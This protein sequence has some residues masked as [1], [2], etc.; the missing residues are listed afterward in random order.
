VLEC[1]YY[2]EPLDNHKTHITKA[3]NTFFFSL[4]KTHSQ[5]NYYFFALL[6]NRI[7]IN[8]FGDNKTPATIDLQLLNK[9]HEHD[10][11]VTILV[12]V[13]V[14]FPAQFNDISFITAQEQAEA[15]SRT[16]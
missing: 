6:T 12:Y 5:S 9:H 16:A 7:C 8:E 2:E 3:L 11:G 10:L 4:S 15:H 14:V 1:H 13:H